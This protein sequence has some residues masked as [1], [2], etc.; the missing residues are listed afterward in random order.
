MEGLSGGGT[1]PSSCGP[2]PVAKATG[3]LAA[4]PR[5]RAGVPWPP[6]C[7]E[8]GSISALASML[9]GAEPQASI[10]EY[11]TPRTIEG[12]GPSIARPG[13]GADR[14]WQ[15][16]PGT[17]RCATAGETAAAWR[18]GTGDLSRPEEYTGTGDDAAGR[19]ELGETGRTA[20]GDFMREAGP[21]ESL[22]VGG[23]VAHPVCSVPEQACISPRIV[24]LPVLGAA[25]LLGN[26][27]SPSTGGSASCAF[28][29]SRAL[30]R[31]GPCSTFAVPA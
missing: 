25:R 6:M 23:T 5:V 10:G 12:P 7:L 2:G 15:L 4:A 27:P 16:L 26:D 20:R 11:G 29:G 13:A 1:A 3:A 19:A 21:G 22:A 30:A 9:D 28:G 14:L 24:A 8:A 31:S 17:A 18:T